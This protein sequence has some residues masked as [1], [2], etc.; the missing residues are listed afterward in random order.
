MVN[1]NNSI[2]NG[3]NNQIL[4]SND[5]MVINGKN[6]IISDRKS[7]TVVG[8]GIEPNLDNAFYIGCSNGL[9]CSGDVVAYSASDSRLKDNIKRVDN[10]LEKVLSLQAIKFDWNTELSGKK[11]RDIGLIAQEV[12]KIAPEIVETRENG[13]KAIKYEKITTLLVGAIQ[14]QQGIIE[15]LEKEVDNFIKS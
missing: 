15:N 4:R 8:D 9:Y 13:Y 1:N 6:N 5:C 3:Y 10:C 14:E 12:E 7:V 11:G 2:L